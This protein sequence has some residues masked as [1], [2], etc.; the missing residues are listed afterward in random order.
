MVWKQS[1]VFDAKEIYKLLIQYVTNAQEALSG[2]RSFVGFGLIVVLWIL[3]APIIAYKITPLIS[4]ID[5]MYESRWEDKGGV[6]F[7]EKK[8]WQTSSMGSSIVHRLVVW[9]F[10]AKEIIKTPILGT[11]LGTSRLIGQNVE[12]HVPLSKTNIKGA[13]P[14]HPHNNALEIY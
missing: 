10:V 8:P 11:G 9:E 6:S 5:K 13:I 3:S 2:P 7:V 14:L 12:L 1:S 4:N